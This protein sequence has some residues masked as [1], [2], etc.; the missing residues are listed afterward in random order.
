MRRFGLI[1]MALAAVALG[2]CGASGRV[3]D[4]VADE[5]PS[6][7]PTTVTSDATTTSRPDGPTDDSR[8]AYS[9]AWSDAY[10]DL[11]GDDR[12]VSGRL[13]D[14]LGVDRLNEAGV[15]AEA[16]AAE[17]VLEALEVDAAEREQLVADVTKAFQACNTA[18]HLA[19]VWLTS[20]E[21]GE[22]YTDFTDCVAGPLSGE[23]AQ[24]VVD[25]LADGQPDSV[26]DATTA[27][28]EVADAA[29][30]ELQ[31][32]VVRRAV[33]EDGPP[34]TAEEEACLLDGYQQLAA[35]HRSLTADDDDQIAD[36]CFGG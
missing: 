22:E 8:A 26:F 29:C 34:L 4:H 33:T 31:V 24:L 15:T 28:L 2:G 17:P 19:D 11:S 20:E 3:S 27:A 5:S 13:V 25:G 35:E 10:I 16:F 36:T 30:A 14:L 21:E 6:S 1:L 23:L 12:C 32:E 7:S 18:D 9:V